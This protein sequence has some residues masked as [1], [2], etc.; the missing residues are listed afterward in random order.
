MSKNNN[1]Y[2]ITLI[3]I[4]TNDIKIM[5]TF[6]NDL[7]AHQFIQQNVEEKSKKGYENVF[8]DNK[9]IYVYERING[10]VTTSKKLKFIYQIHKY[11][12]YTDDHNNIE[13][14]DYNKSE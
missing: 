4:D 7:K 11:N 2:I 8:V 13:T 6:Q 5:G 10:W 1:I 9:K 3:E 12:K 14:T